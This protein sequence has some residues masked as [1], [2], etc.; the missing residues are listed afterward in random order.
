MTTQ[1]IIVTVCN[2]GV[3]V[4]QFTPMHSSLSERFLIVSLG[5]ADFLMGAYLLGISSADL[6]Y[7]RVFYMY[8]VTLWWV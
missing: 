4:T 7:N 5:F 8:I 6:I 3:L 2:I 1:G